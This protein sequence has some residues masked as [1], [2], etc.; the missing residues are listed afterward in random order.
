MRNPRQQAAFGES[1]IGNSGKRKTYFG[2]PYAEEI[3][4]LSLELDTGRH[5]APCAAGLLY[6]V[7]LMTRMHSFIRFLLTESGWGAEVGRCRL[8]L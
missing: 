6:A 7:R 4:A 3:L 8:T 1:S 2:W 5:D